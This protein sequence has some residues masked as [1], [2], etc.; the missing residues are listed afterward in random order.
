MNIIKNVFKLIKAELLKYP[1]ECNICGYKGRFGVY[2][3]IPRIS[4]L[5]P[6]CFSL[7]RHRLLF[8]YLRKNELKQPIIHFAAEFCISN[9]CRNRY[10]NYKTAD[11]YKPSDLKVD[12]ECMQLLDSKIG[13][14]IANHVMQCVDDTKALP[15][16][17]RVLKPG[18]LLI[19]TVPLSQFEITSGEKNVKEK[20]ESI[21][22][23]LSH[24]NARIYGADFSINIMKYGFKLVSRFTGDSESMYRFGI[25]INEVV[26]VFE[27]C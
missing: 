3:I 23:Y 5:C 11:L 7:E 6:N 14:I 18:G 8:E 12:I 27:K 19:C 20:K 22:R 17:Y 9:H 13:S 25:T 15:E 21:D 24:D 10:T 16:I 4:A 26:F 2:G 1:T